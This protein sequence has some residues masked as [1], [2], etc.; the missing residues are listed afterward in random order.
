MVPPNEYCDVGADPRTAQ[1]FLT[2][3]NAKHIGTDYG[4]PGNYTAKYR[5]N[6]KVFLGDAKQ[7]AKEVL[8]TF[9]RNA[10]QTTQCR[11]PHPGSWRYRIPFPPVHCKRVAF[12]GFAEMPG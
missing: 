4:S 12:M 11:R 3:T 2:G 5:G 7:N 1:G 6:A 10:K 8:R 9:Q